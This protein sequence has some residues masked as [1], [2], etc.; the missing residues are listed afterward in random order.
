MSKRAA[1]VMEGQA[2]N[3][4][5]R[6]RR[7]MLAFEAV[8]KEA[9]LP[10]DIADLLEEVNIAAV[11]IGNIAGAL[12]AGAQ[13]ERQAGKDW[14]NEHS[15]LP[16]RPRVDGEIQIP[17]PVQEEWFPSRIKEERDGMS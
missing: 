13:E 16:H 11:D 3:L 17:P 4:R 7:L 2:T 1:E 15:K 5:E 8:D 14:W 10:K 9:P 6:A 12:S